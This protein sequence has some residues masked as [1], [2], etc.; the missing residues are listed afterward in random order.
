MQQIYFMWLLC[1]NKYMHNKQY[2]AKAKWF[3]NQNRLKKN[4]KNKK[5]VLLKI[6][7]PYACVQVENSALKNH[8]MPHYLSDKI[9]QTNLFCLVLPKKKF[10]RSQHFCMQIILKLTP[11]KNDVQI[12]YVSFL[13]TRWFSAWRLWCRRQ[14]GVWWELCFRCF[15]ILQLL[16]VLVHCHRLIFWWGDGLWIHWVPVASSLPALAQWPNL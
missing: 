9:M 10:W 3:T 14:N 16:I 12:S 7:S 2:F 15:A 8:K 13:A 4:I 5:T 6:M 1:M 11:W